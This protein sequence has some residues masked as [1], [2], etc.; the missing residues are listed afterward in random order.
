MKSS[1]D[2]E[3]LPYY[4]HVIHFHGMYYLNVSKHKSKL[5]SCINGRF[6]IKIQDLF[7]FS[8]FLRLLSLPLLSSKYSLLPFKS[9]VSLFISCYYMHMY[10]NMHL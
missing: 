7:L 4:T 5:Y 3:V 9:T 6:I 8:Y 10:M 1:N 2:S